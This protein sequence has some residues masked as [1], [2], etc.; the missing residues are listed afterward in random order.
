MDFQSRVSRFSHRCVATGGQH[1]TWHAL[2][3]LFSE[4]LSAIILNT[5]QNIHRTIATNESKSVAVD[6]GLLATCRVI[7][8]LEVQSST[9]S[10][11]Y[12]IRMRAQAP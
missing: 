8:S 2:W 12:A 11:Q 10:E 4:L 1:T 7:S 3:L 5:C 6:R 9:M